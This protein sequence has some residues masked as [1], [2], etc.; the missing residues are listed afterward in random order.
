MN[1]WMAWLVSEN[2]A[3]P[4]AR[5]RGVSHVTT[6]PVTWE[7][8]G[9]PTSVKLWAWKDGTVVPAGA[10]PIEPT[11]RKPDGWATWYYKRRPRRR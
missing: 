2:F 5:R 10:T 11:G 9:C 1:A 7:A 6:N 3:D 4:K 8:A